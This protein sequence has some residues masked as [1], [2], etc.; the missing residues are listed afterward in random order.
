MYSLSLKEVIKKS[1]EGNLIPLFCE[2]PSDLHTPVSAFLKLRTGKNDFLLESVAGG[3]TWGRYSIL[4]LG[5]PESLIIK[6]NEL[7]HVSSAGD[8]IKTNNKPFET[9]RDFMKAFRPV[10]V[11]GLPRFYGG[12][13][14]FLTYDLVREFEKIPATARDELGLDTARFLIAKNLVVFDNLRQVI[15]VI[16]NL[17]LDGTPVQKIYETA[18]HQIDK[19]IEQLKAPLPA[20]SNTPISHSTSLKPLLS[21]E[22]FCV[23]VE[24]A[25]EYIRAGDIFQVQISNRFEG[26]FSGDPFELYRALRRINPSPY[27]FFMQ[28]SDLTLVGA[29]PEIMVRKTG[30]E[31]ALRPIAGTRRRGRTPAEDI[32]LETELRHDPKERAEH[33][34]LVDLGRN[35][36]GR[37]CQAGSVKVGDLEIVERYSHVMHLVSHVSGKLKTGMGAFDLISATFPAGTLTGAPKIRS[38]EIIEELEG[39]R[40]GVYGGAVGYISFSDDTDMAITIRTALIKDKKVY[41]QAAG[42]IVFDSVPQLEFKESVNKATAM[43]KAL[44]SV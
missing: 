31:V 2:I 5:I 38:M 20:K 43:M 8:Q 7:H 1:S 28:F 16:A 19:I 22:Q 36:L 34:M 40:R 14:G 39:R 29:S 25:K 23:L 27:L 10:P 41:V 30:D 33:V 13:A 21:E 3:E 12:L 32:A 11:D 26:D 4:G 44:A 24:K 9:C 6:N 15:L 18:T 37:V 42:G 35:D 17:H